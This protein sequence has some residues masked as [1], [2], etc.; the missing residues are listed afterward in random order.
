MPARDARLREHTWNHLPVDVGEAEVA[1]LGTEGELLV[2]ESE[3]MQEG[4]LQIVD[5]DFVVGDGEAEFVR[6][7]VSGSGADPGAGHENGKAVGVMV[8]SEDLACGGPAFAERSA[9]EF[10]T[11]NNQGV[12]QESAAAQVLN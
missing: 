12:V 2:V 10:T 8:A 1:A 11:P 6:F 7:T 5:M 9:A 3:Q 4:G